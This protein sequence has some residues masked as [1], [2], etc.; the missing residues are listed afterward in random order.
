MITM[1]RFHDMQQMVL[2]LTFRDIERG[3]QLAGGV[4]GVRQESCELLAIRERKSHG[5][6]DRLPGWMV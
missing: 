3:R 1:E 2:D 4:P 6:R 5:V